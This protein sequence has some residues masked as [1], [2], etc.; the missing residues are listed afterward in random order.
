M[1]LHVIA[2]LQVE[3]LTGQLADM[4]REVKDK[5]RLSSTLEATERSRKQVRHS[6]SVSGRAPLVHHSS[7]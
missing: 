5:G 1:W 7:H 6:E 3:F 4:Q 2:C